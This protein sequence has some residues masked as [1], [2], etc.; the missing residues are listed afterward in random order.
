MQVG[1]LLTSEA[2][3]IAT[4]LY[5]PI[6]S[7]F[8]HRVHSNYYAVVLNWLDLPA[9]AVSAYSVYLG[10]AGDEFAIEWMSVAVMMQWVRQLRVLLL[11][12]T[13]APGVLVFL[14]MMADI[15][16]WSVLFIV[17]LLGYAGALRVLYSAPDAAHLGD[18]PEYCSAEGDGAVVATHVWATRLFE[19]VFSLG[20]LHECLSSSAWGRAY[21]YLFLVFMYVVMINLLIAIMSNTFS[22]VE[23]ASVTRPTPASSPSPVA[24]HP[25]PHAPTTSPSPLLHTLS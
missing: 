7:L 15:A 5:R 4:S 11:V 14:A 17:M 6:A 10:L 13:V 22:V 12:P 24:R 18:V 19:A 25:M 9:A 20:S 1:A 16:K 8:S 21:S 2:E 23:E 3:G